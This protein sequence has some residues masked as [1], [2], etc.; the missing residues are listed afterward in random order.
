MLE[1]A[2]VEDA[3]L[4][5]VAAIQC[6]NAAEAIVQTMYHVPL[7]LQ[8]VK[9]QAVGTTQIIQTVN[10]LKPMPKSWA[11]FWG[12]IISPLSITLPTSIPDNNL[13]KER[14]T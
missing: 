4:L 1:Q 13:K 6:Q 14:L 12:L 3:G 2:Q 5:V 8:V 9:K 11:F 10:S 7:A